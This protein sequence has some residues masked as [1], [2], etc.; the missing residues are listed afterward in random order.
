VG[1]GR[2]GVITGRILQGFGCR[3]LAYDPYPPIEARG[4]G[5][6]FHSVE[7]LLARSEIVSLHCPLLPDTR[8]IINA[9]SLARMRPGALLINTSRGGLIDTPAVLSALERNHL[10]GLGIDVYE[11][12]ASLFFQ[13]HT[14]TGI[15]D[16]LFARLVNLPNVVATGHQ[17][18]LTHDAL[19]NIATSVIGSLDAF[20]GGHPVPL[21]LRPRM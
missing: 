10:G 20:S 7:E 19:E 4:I 3:V 17:G 9:E 13:D 16:P 12:E 18:F 1:I 5:F 8:H 11:H 21:A 6:E 14:A 15:P 2:I